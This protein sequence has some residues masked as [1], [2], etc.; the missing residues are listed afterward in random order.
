MLG[1]ILELKISVLLK[2]M[3]KCG[4]SYVLCAET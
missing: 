4:R 2:V 1:T 3:R